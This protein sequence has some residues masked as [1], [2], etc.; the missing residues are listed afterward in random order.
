MEKHLRIMSSAD[1]EKKKK[2]EEWKAA[3]RKADNFSGFP[4]Q[5]G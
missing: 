5:D 1:E 3:L 2:V 4:L